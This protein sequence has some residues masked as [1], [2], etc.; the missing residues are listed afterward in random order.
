MIRIVIS[1]LV[2]SLFTK[3]SPAQVINKSFMHNGVQ[4]NY[5]LYIPANYSSTTPAPLVFNFHGFT[6]NGSAQFVSSNF[7]PIADTAGFIVVSPTGTPLP[8]LGLN[9]WNVGGWTNSSTADD[10]SF[11][12][13]M[14]DSVSS[15]YSI[16]H[17]RIYATGM[18]NGGFFSHKLAC[19]LS[20][21]IAAIA[22]VSGTFTNEMR[23]NCNPIHP[24][25]VLQIHGTTDGVV[26]YNGTT[27]N[28]GMIAVDTVINYWVQYNNCSRTPTISALP[29]TVVGDGSTVE[30]YIYAGGDAGVTV[31]L[32]KITNGGH[33]WPG[34]SGNMDITASL[35][36][37]H[38]FAKYSLISVGLDNID[39]KPVLNIY[40]NPTQQFIYVKGLQSANIPYVLYSSTGKTLKS[41][42]LNSSHS[43]VDV[44]QYAEGVYYLLVNQLAYKII[45]RD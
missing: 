20:D 28:G 18:S 22:S 13:A 5:Q 12:A 30:R 9:H 19:E 27:G 31:E 25:P 37:W 16:D 34:T 41:G 33:D 42:S 14:I 38:F 44:S 43:R 39:D 29:N 36:I 21:R 7:K 45:K 15:E 6:S 26:P 10:V 2:L 17:M 11:V 24:T 35:E 8:P 40:P 3:T 32:L 23:L 1:L 4:R